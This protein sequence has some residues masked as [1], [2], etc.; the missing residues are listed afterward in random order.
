MLALFSCT[1]QSSSGGTISSIPSGEYTT[2]FCTQEE[3][4]VTVTYL[5]SGIQ[6]TPQVVQVPFVMWPTAKLSVPPGTTQVKLD[7]TC[8][9]KRS[10]YTTSITRIY[11]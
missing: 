3:V 8:P 7:F 1:K 9:V 6:Q 10:I 11:L 4:A 2:E 5:P